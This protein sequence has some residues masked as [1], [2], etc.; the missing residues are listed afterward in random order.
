MK[1]YRNVSTVITVQSTYFPFFQ[2]REKDRR[3]R[4]KRSPRSPSPKS[5][6]S[7]SEK[8]RKIS[9]RKYD[10]ENDK[11]VSRNSSKNSERK[12]YLG[13]RSGSK[14]SI[15]KKWSNDSSS[16][17]NKIDAIAKPEAQVKPKEMSDEILNG[18]NDNKKNVHSD[19]DIE[20]GEI[21]EEENVE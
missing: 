1:G 16:S 15:T 11:N 21:S 14:R 10:K 19:V 12:S 8:Y 20:D 3:E 18:E 5:R 13:N 9:E 17:T 7:Y 2:F 6:S 4:Q